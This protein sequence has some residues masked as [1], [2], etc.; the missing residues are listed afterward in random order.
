MER[1]KNQMTL[2]YRY[3]E[4]A[5]DACYVGFGII[6]DGVN[7]KVDRCLFCRNPLVIDK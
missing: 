7:Y 3:K 4:K 5:C 2:A 1:K 6:W